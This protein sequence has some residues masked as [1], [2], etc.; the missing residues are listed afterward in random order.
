MI[1]IT[2]GHEIRNKRILAQKKI[3]IG[4]GLPTHGQAF[5]ISKITEEV[6]REIGQVV[7]ARL[8][9]GFCKWRIVRSR[10]PFALK[11]H[12]LTLKCNPPIYH[13]LWY[14]FKF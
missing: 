14:N 11:P 6:D 13:W 3:S 10:H 8:D 4:H 12:R 7:W 2:Y 9:W 5:L 1:E